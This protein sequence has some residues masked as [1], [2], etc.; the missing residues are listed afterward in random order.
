MYPANSFEVLY[1]AVGCDESKHV[2]FETIEVEIV[3]RPNGGFLDGAVYSLG[4]ALNSEMVWIGEVVFDAF[5]G[6][7]TV[8]DMD[9][10]ILAA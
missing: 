5:F 1:K 9:V 8:K 10:Q 2:G 7:D 3:E 6:A 4:L